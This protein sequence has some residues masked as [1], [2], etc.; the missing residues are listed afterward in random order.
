[1]IL[2]TIKQIF[3]QHYNSVSSGESNDNSNS[4]PYTSSFKLKKTVTIQDTNI[5]KQHECIETIYQYQR[6]KF[7]DSINIEQI[8]KHSTEQY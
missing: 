7:K 3:K 6:V 8:L 4:K 1:M 5:Y 2:S